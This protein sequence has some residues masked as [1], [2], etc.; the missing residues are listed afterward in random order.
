MPGGSGVRDNPGS[1]RSASLGVLGKTWACSKHSQ[2]THRALAGSLEV[3]GTT[4]ACRKW[5]TITRTTLAGHSHNT[6]RAGCQGLGGSRGSG[7]GV[8]GIIGA[9]NIHSAAATTACPRM[10]LC[11]SCFESGFNG[12]DTPASPRLRHRVRSA[13]RPKKQRATDREARTHTVALKHAAHTERH[14]VTCTLRR[15]V[16]FHHSSHGCRLKTPSCSPCASGASPGPCPPVTL[17][18]PRILGFLTKIVYKFEIL[19]VRQTQRVFLTTC[20]L[21]RLHKAG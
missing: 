10:D 12:D 1:L 16:C 7:F 21:S 13:P 6:R 9:P 8:L 18:A 2:G 3:L 4:W 11:N 19:L 15:R 5:L 20:E 14:A 17:L